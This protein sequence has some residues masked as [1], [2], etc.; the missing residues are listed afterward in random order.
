MSALEVNTRGPSRTPF[1]GKP[2]AVLDETG[3]MKIKASDPTE[4]E[5]PKNL[6]VSCAKLVMLFAIKKINSEKIGCQYS[7]GVL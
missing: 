1:G 4:L 5:R 7:T 3:G 2:R 6:Q